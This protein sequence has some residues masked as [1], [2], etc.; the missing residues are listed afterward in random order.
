MATSWPTGVVLARGRPATLRPANSPAT[1]LPVPGSSPMM[2]REVRVLPEPDSPTMQVV[3]PAQTSHDTPFTT[4]SPPV[5][6]D[7]NVAK[8]KEG[9]SLT[10]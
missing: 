6:G 7:L 9:A 5:K 10:G 2:A 8:G 3:A 4:G 1:S